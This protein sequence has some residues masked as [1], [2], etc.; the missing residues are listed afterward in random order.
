MLNTK[1]ERFIREIMQSL[2]IQVDGER[3]WDVRIHNPL[4]YKRVA[5]QGSLGLGEAYMDGWWDCDALDELFY[6]L[7]R[8][9]ADEKTADT[10]LRKIYKSIKNYLVSVQN[11]IQRKTR[12]FIIGQHHYDLGNELFSIMLD[13]GLNYSCAYWHKA[14]NLQQAQTEKLDLICRKIGLMPGMK[15]L[16]IGCGWGGFARHAAQNY[17]VKVTGVTVSKE[18]ADYARNVCKEL[19]VTVEL[20]DYRQVQGKYDRVVSVGM[21]EHVG[22]RN[23]RRFMDKVHQV[24]DNSGLFLLHTI[25]SNDSLTASD[26]W[27]GTYIFPHSMIPSVAQICRAAERRFIV[28]DWHNFGLYYDS[29]LMVWYKNFVNNYHKIKERYDLRFFR[30]WTYYLLV[31][32]ASFRARKNQLWQIVFS[33]QGLDRVFRS[34]GELFP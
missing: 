19:D 9:K 28:E 10:G 26:P 27:I 24:L 30:M 32:A 15:V 21:F 8:N 34:E 2:D 29:T 14:E 33:K 12:A 6:R 16:D 20:V 5:T 23:Y 25:G 18:Q 17:G 3:P 13:K 22:W 4:F 7:L 31:S 1:S 11:Q